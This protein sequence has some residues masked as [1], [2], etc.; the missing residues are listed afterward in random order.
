LSGERFPLVLF[1][2]ELTPDKAI[3]FT[4]SIWEWD[5]AEDMFN[6]WREHISAHAGNIAQIAL[7]VIS[8]VKSGVPNIGDVVKSAVDNNIGKL[9]AATA[10]I[11]GRAEKIIYY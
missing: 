8:L 1:E 10:P 3:T 6:T 2:G 5:G 9:Y 4:I 11:L 7:N